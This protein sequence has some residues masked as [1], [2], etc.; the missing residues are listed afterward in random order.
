MIYKPD[1]KKF[2]IYYILCWLPSALVYF[3]HEF[4]P[5]FNI[6]YIIYAVLSGL[7]AVIFVAGWA[8]LTGQSAFEYP[9]KT[10]VFI[11]IYLGISTLLSFAVPYLTTVYPGYSVTIKF[12]GWMFFY[13]PLEYIILSL[14]YYLFSDQITAVIIMSC[15]LTIAFIIGA[16]RGKYVR[17]R[18]GE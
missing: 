17:H 13:I 7:F 4:V 1:F 12:V 5:R 2:P 6:P 10:V 9:V 3:L 11:V 8:V 18:R 16:L 14:P 15:A